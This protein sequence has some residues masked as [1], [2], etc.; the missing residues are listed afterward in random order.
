MRAYP[1]KA[2]SSMTLPFAL[3]GFMVSCVAGLS[4]MG[5]AKV[6]LVERPGVFEKIMRDPFLTGSSA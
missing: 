2:G 3:D 1:L 6:H 4:S 5:A